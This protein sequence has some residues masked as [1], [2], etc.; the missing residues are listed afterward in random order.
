M[1]GPG[2]HGQVG[3]RAGLDLGTDSTMGVSAEHRTQENSPSSDR[4]GGLRRPTR[5]GVVEEEPLVRAL[6]CRELAADPCVHVVHSVGTAREAHATFLPGACDVEV[7]SADLPDDSGVQVG[8]QLQRSDPAVAVLLLCHPDDASVADALR[9]RATQGWSLLSRRSPATAATFVRAVHAARAGRVIRDPSIAS[10]GR[11]PAGSIAD[12]TSVQ[13]GVLRLV[14][15]GMSNGAAARQLGVGQRTVESHLLAI[16]RRLSID[17][18]DANPRVA[19][20]LAFL[21]GTRRLVP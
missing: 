10:V 5:V 6:L 13:V 1:P 14:A 17:R 3:S 2:R 18:G 12:L 8:L 21:R 16:Y 20:T 4:S 9:R 7:V 15:Q 19:A 11:A